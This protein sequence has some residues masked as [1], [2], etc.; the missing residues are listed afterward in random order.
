[1]RMVETCSVMS[2][3]AVRDREMVVAEMRSRGC[4]GLR[5]M[6]GAVK[7]GRRGT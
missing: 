5:R 4:I 7:R 2:A 3:M 6:S 1:M